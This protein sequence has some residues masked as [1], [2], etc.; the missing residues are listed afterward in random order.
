M[1]ERPCFAGILSHE[2]ENTYYTWIVRRCCFAKKK[3]KLEQARLAKIKA[4]YADCSFSLWRQSRNSSSRELHLIDA[5]SHAI[6]KKKFVM[7][8]EAKE[9]ACF[10]K[11][12]CWK[13]YGAVLSDYEQY[14]GGEIVHGLAKSLWTLCTSFLFSCPFVHFTLAVFSSCTSKLLLVII[15]PACSCHPLWGR[16]DRITS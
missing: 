3:K 14:Q 13:P 11:Q 1:L 12:N 4:S 15:L 6:E 5:L 7:P 2:S 10:L 8:D 9:K 16:P